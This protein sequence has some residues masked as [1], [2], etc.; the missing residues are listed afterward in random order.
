[1]DGRTLD[2]ECKTREQFM[3]WFLGLQALCPLSYK[4][5]NRSQLNWHRALYKT[6]QIAG[7]SGV[8]ITTVWN[9]LVALSRKELAS[10]QEYE[11]RRSSSAIVAA[12]PAQ[13][14]SAGNRNSSG[15][16]AV[17]LNSSEPIGNVVIRENLAKQALTILPASSP[18][19][20]MQ[21]SLSSQD[22]VAESKSASLLAKDGGD[23]DDEIDASSPMKQVDMS[24]VTAPVDASRFTPKLKSESSESKHPNGK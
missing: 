22:D 18:T 5:W 11:R 15:T 23:S 9:D 2:I 1:M 6:L 4:F 12:N 20:I 21:P 13:A 14:A 17:V 24:I 7:N 10:K 8:D 19:S 3:T 16:G